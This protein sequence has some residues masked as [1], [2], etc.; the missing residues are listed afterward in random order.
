MILLR[1]L[2]YRGGAANATAEDNVVLDSIV[3]EASAVFHAGK[4]YDA[5]PSA[6]REELRVFARKKGFAVDSESS[7]GGC[8]LSYTRCSQP[9]R[10]AASEMVSGGSIE[11]EVCTSCSLTP[12]C[13]EPRF[14]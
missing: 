9:S 8:K 10:K 5:P 13:P 14:K 3:E 7:S 11:E 2:Y 4:V 12:F 6:I 1:E